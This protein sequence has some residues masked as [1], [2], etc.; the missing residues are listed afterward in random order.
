MGLLDRTLRGNL[1]SPSGSSDVTLGALFYG[2]DRLPTLYNGN[3][4][5]A[6]NYIFAHLFPNYQATVANP[7]ALPVSANPND[8]YIVSD[9][10]DGK[11][12]G[13]VWSVVDNVGAWAK[14]YDVD[15]SYEGIYAETINRTQ[16]MYA[17]KYGMTDKD[18]SGTAITG[19]YAGQR[20]YGGDLTAQNLTFNANSADG[21]GY[22][23]TDNTFRPT[24][25]NALDLGTSALK[26]RTAYLGTSLVVGTLTVGPASITDSSGAID[27]GDEDL[28]TSGDLEADVITAL[29]SVEVGTLSIQTGSITDSSGTIDFDNEDLTTTGTITAGSSTLGDITLGTGS[30]TSASATI[31]F[32][33]NN[34]STT[35]TIGAGDAQ[36]TRVDSDN[37]RLDGNTLSALDVNG[38]VVIVANG[39][40]IIDLQSAVTTLGITATGT[41]GITG[42]LNIDN[43]RLDANTVSSTDLN[44]N[45]AL[46]P[47]GTGLVTTSAS[48]LPSADGTLDLGATAFRFNDLFLDGAISDGTTSISQ[49]TLQSLRD[50]N[51]G[52]VAGDALFYDGSKW[53][54]SP[55][56]TE[57][58][59]S[60]LNGLTTGDAGHTQFVVLAG[61]SG[62]QTVQGGTGAG[63]HLV[64]ESTSNASKG[65]VLT[66][67]VLA[68]FTTASYSGGWL[69]TDLGGSA[70]IFRDVYTKGEFLGLRF[71][72]VAT[73]PSNS[74]QNVGR[75]VYNTAE[76]KL[77][78]DTGTMWISAGGS[79][80]KF[81]S[82]TVWNGSD[83]TKDIDVSSTILDART[84]IW[85]LCDNSNDFERVFTS[86]KAIS[87]TTV[88][89][90]V[91]PALPA[92]SYR[93]IGLN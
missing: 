24:S 75:A 43:L 19:L 86:I 64:L 8:Y 79:G 10:G 78:I 9:D 1:G 17:S 59:H 67:D 62:G 3:A 56:D 34:L 44:G 84:A 42:Q 88:R 54:A 66:R 85:Q 5:A 87:A 81:F 83:T 11:S 49:S 28:S 57:I 82:D 51:V 77:Y 74:A 32:G 30:I 52:A 36:F 65:L 21:T 90:T 27:F 70:N 31:S 39:T 33:T 38:N 45:I 7:A 53:V 14:R 92:G 40:G 93:L 55:P 48:L 68:P 69:G 91:D 25:D 89:I 23:Q 26:F 20:I 12:A 15:W 2:N 72:N 29:T 73:N 18:D 4:E 37:L 76:E 61:R 60:E 58:E 46:S 22:V 80:E 71:Q 63:E 50:I 6:L 16:Y 35:G 47:N 41:V 13:Y